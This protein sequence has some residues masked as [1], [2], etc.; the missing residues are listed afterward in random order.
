MLISGHVTP[1]NDPCN[2]CCNGTKKLLDN[3]QEKLL[4]ETAPSVSEFGVQLIF[5]E[6]A[7]LYMF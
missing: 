6:A 4:T 7:E 5:R 1:G 3:L 2:L